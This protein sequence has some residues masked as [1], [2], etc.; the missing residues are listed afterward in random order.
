MSN[1]TNILLFVAFLLMALP[2]VV[3]ICTKL[4]AY[5]W[6]RGRYLFFEDQKKE[7]RDDEERQT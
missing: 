1:L 5:A 6:Y 7:K 4:A 3:Y 2:F